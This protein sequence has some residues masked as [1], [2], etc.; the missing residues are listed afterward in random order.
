M[1]PRHRR[2]C[3][4]GN[5]RNRN[6]RRDSKADDT[7]K[8]NLDIDV[9][10]VRGLFLNSTSF[11]QHVASQ[12][13]D[14]FYYQAALLVLVEHKLELSSGSKARALAA[15][16][17]RHDHEMTR[18]M[19]G[20]P[21]IFG[22]VEVTKALSMLDAG[23]MLKKNEKRLAKLTDLQENK[24]HKVRKGKFAKLKSAIGNLETLKVKGSLSGAVAKQI[25]KWTITIPENELD[26]YAL[27]YPKEPWKTVADLCHLNPKKDFRLDWFLP[28][29]FGAEAP[30]G[31]L[32]YQCS[33]L[34]KENL[35]E[36]LSSAK[37]PYA[38]L[39]KHK[40]WFND[41]SKK[42]DRTKLGCFNN[43]MVVRRLEKSCS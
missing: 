37:I 17:A 34:T 42:T 27:H 16:I 39:K 23:R 6:S 1:N 33:Q 36:V 7:Q 43:H 10:D 11:D 20:L 35:N 38:Y 28:F 21:E 31:S 4:R 9:K 18:M 8:V 32:T 29:C 12:K 14:P 24:G 13:H 26:F 25:K 22:M 19:L 15:A 2:G 41:D 3:G 40:D 5:R 30:E